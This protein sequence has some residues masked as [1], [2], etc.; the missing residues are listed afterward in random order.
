MTQKFFVNSE[1]LYVGSYD[2][3]DEDKP[4]WFDDTIEV[5]KIPEDPSWVWDFVKKKWVTT[6]TIEQLLKYSGDKRWD[7]ENGGFEIG[8][9]HIATDDRSKTMITGARIAS[10]A[11]SEF[12]TPWKTPDGSFTRITAPVIIMISNAML[13]HVDACFNKEEEVAQLIN[14]DVITT[15]EQIDT[16]WADEAL[17]NR[18]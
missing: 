8:G 12:S 5:T 6:K 2:G 13:D 11:N 10:D 15:I 4:D 17:T 1:G 7:K 16:A 3:P 14:T 18:G 9:M